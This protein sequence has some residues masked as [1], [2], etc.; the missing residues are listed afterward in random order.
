MAR[1]KDK[2]TCNHTQ[3]VEVRGNWSPA[4]RKRNGTRYVCIHCG[5]LRVVYFNG[6]VEIIKEDK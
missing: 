5:E 2:R 4:G 3:F 1:L 6:K